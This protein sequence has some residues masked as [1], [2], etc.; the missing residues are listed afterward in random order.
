MNA[1]VEVP[2]VDTEPPTVSINSPNS[3]DTVSHVAILSSEAT[4][5]LAIANVEFYVDGA[6]VGIDSVA[7]YS[8]NWDTTAVANVPHVVT[9]VARDHSG[10]QT[11]S[12]PV[13]VSTLNPAFVNEIVVPDVFDATTIAFLPDGRMLVGELSNKVLMVQPG[14]SQPDPQPILDLDY[15]S[16]GLQPGEQGLMDIAID[17]NF[18]Q[19]GY[20]YVYYTKGFG[21]QNHNRL[22]RFT[23]SGNVVTANSETVLW[24]DDRVANA[25]HH[26]GSTGFGVDGKIYFTTGD[27]FSGQAPSQQLDNYWGKVL[28]INTNGSI[29]LDNPFYDGAG[30]NRDEIWAYGLRNPYRMSID[31]LSGRMYIGDVGGNDGNTAIEELNLG[32]A[33]A[34]YGW[35]LGEGETGIPGT[36]D[37]IFSYAHNNLESAITAGFIYHGSQFP[38]EYQGSFFFGDYANNTIKRLTLDANGNVT[39]VVNFWPAD[40]SRDGS[41]VGDPVKLVEGPDGSLYYVDI[42]F[43][44]AYQ[45]NPAAIRRIRYSVANQPPVA[46]AMADMTVGLP[47]LTVNFSSAGSFDPEGQP[48]SYLWTF[49]DGGTSTDA[50][51]SHTYLVAGKYTAMLSVSDLD[52]STLSTGMSIQVGNL[53]APTI[54]TPLADTMFRAGDVISYVGTALDFEDGDLPA[55]AFNWTILFHHESHIHPAG[56]FSD[57]TSGTLTIPTTGHD[58]LGETSYEIVLTVTDSTGLSNSTSVSVYPEKVNLSFDSLPTGLTII[59]DGINRQTPFVLDDLISFEHTIAAPIQSSGGVDYTFWRWSDGGSQTHNIVVPSTDQSYLALFA[60]TSVQL[61]G[62]YNGDDTVNAADY[63]VWR[64]TLGTSTILLNDV[65]PGSVT[66]NDYSVW[67]VNYGATT[68]GTGAAS[69]AFV[70]SSPTGSVEFA[71]VFD[72]TSPD[73]SSAAAVIGATDHRKVIADRALDFATLGRAEMPPVH[74]IR[75]REIALS[76]SGWES[77]LLT[78]LRHSIV[79]TDRGQPVAGETRVASERACSQNPCFDALDDLFAEF[80]ALTIG[81][82]T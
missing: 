54:S 74:T 73:D 55:S 65:T 32:I 19:N 62:D 72:P 12:D 7:P 9:A 21:G 4:D 42:G 49:G 43:D 35:P 14:A 23:V 45:P 80:E 30:P 33:G 6:S 25:E 20:F 70:S 34:N 61:P 2:P 48:L 79:T 40:G 60:P 52:S 78:R 5:N 38:S 76:Q 69:D 39:G 31:P 64:N 58:F 44:T 47:P 11:T 36:T 63:S 56:V 41:V 24:Q 17:P 59:V 51:P 16:L 46:V 28:R 26:G 67:K 22:S 29:P 1:P 71:S 27:E 75:A 66:V 77:L 68:L 37:P 18:S 13:N 50:N 57:T 15:A 81:R 53:P 3:G 8:I 82:L 10:N